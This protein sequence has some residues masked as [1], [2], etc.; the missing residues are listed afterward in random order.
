MRP[1]AW[2]RVL[3]RPRAYRRSV[4]AGARR[5][6]RP[7]PGGLS[8]DGG[9]EGWH[10]REPL[11]LRWSNP[12]RAAVAAVHYRGP[13]TLWA[14]RV[15]EHDR[16]RPVSDGIHRLSVPAA[17]APTRPRSGSRTR[18]AARARPATASCASTMA[19]RARASHRRAPAGSAAPSFPYASGSATRRAASDLG[20]PR[21]CRRRS[22]RL[23]AG[24]PAP[25]ARTLH[26]TPRPTCGAASTTTADVPELPEGT[27]T[28]TPSPSPAPGMSRRRSAAPVLRVDRTDPVDAARGSPG[29][30]D[31]P[32]GTAD[33]DRRRTRLGDGARGD[34]APSP[35]S[36]STAV[37][38]PSAPATRS[39][40][41]WSARASTR[42]LLRARRGRQRRRRRGLPTAGATDPRDP[43]CGSTASRPESPSPARRTRRSGADRARVADPLSGP[44]PTRSRSA[45]APPARA[46][47][48]SRCRPS[49]ARS[50]AAR[51]LGLRGLP[52]RQL[53]IPGDRLRRRRELGLQ[54]R[55]GSM[56]RRWPLQPAQDRRPSWL[57]R[58]SLSAPFPTG[59]A[60]LQRAP[61]RRLGAPSPGYRCGWSSASTP[62]RDPRERHPTVRT[63][64]DGPSRV[65]LGPGPS[66]DG[67][68]RFA[69]SATLT[70]AG[71]PGTAARGTQPG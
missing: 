36:R 68:G 49:V 59:A 32:A 45:S 26:A 62:A 17:P 43:R 56:A 55:S 20:H 25:D 70:R 29:R 13:R 12:R 61:R 35:R 40:R 6:R 34:A 22:T 4:L 9:E 7:P 65:R 69:G 2:C 58:D 33:G 53:R 57:E 37:R 48:S 19:A 23:P 11:L 14:G 18:P 21:L 47:A 28:S 51:P 31:E 10:A 60:P 44:I 3:A 16:A 42:R 8:V 24:G 41:P 39:R 63:G 64:A 1:L 54:P 27:A 52:A 46:T 38:R 15:G 67:R 71:Q 5:R 30:L 66:R 50:G